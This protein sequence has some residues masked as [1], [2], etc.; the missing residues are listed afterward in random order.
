MEFISTL[1]NGVISLFL[2]NP[3]GQLFGFI[4][5][6]VG[7]TGFIVT[8][9]TKTIKIFIAATIF[10][11][12]HFIFMGNYGALLAGI[13][14]LIRLI[15][16]L[17]YKKSV[18]VFM[19]ILAVSIALGLYSFDGKII[20]IIPLIAT[21]ISSYGFFFLEK[22]RLRLLLAG[23]SFMWLFYH[24]NTGSMSGVTNEIIVQ[25]TIIYSVYKF[26]TGAEKKEKILDRFKRRIGRAPVRVNFG[27]YVFY[28]DKD[29][30][31]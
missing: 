14:G 25:G 24:Y 27:R 10:W 16:S 26:M 2:E 7:I 29:R 18:S 23:V 12:L 15:L 8:D 17:K 11:L 6:F 3:L 19:A 22:V 21:A 13:I 30:F 31:E 5:M 20:S 1:L 9:D 28:R 4:A